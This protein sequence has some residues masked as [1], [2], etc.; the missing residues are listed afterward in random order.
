MSLSPL[1]LEAGNALLNNTGIRVAPILT[2]ALNKYN[3]LP[4]I[5]PLLTTISNASGVL[6]AN[7]I[8][9]LQT[10]G[11]N[12]CPA[13]S[14]S[15]P[16]GYTTLTVTT[17]PPGLTGL[18]S[19]T[20]NLY[21]GNGDVSKF[22]QT[23]SVASSYADSVNQFI[24][25]GVNSKTYLANTFSSMDNLTSA[26]LTFVTTDPKAFAKDI[27]KL[28]NL[29]NLANIDQLG[30]PLALVQQVI[31]LGGL[32]GPLI[33]YLGAGGLSSDQIITLINPN[34]DITDSDQKLIYQAMQE[35]T[36]ADLGQILQI[37]EVTTP[38]ITNM[39]DLLD[40]VKIFPNSYQTLI[41][42][43]CS[44]VENIYLPTPSTSST[45][46]NTYIVPYPGRNIKYGE[47]V[48]GYL[49]NAE[50]GSAYTT[51][52]GASGVVDSTGFAN[53]G[54][55]AEY[56][57]GYTTYTVH[58]TTGS[59]SETLFVT[60]P[61]NSWY[62]APTDPAWGSFMQTYA[63]W[64]G[65]VDAVTTN[66]IDTVI[67]CPTSGVYSI[68]YSCDNDL[69]WNFDNGAN[70]TSA[71]N[72]DTS[73]VITQTLS[74][75][76]HTLNISI[77]NTGGPGGVAMRITKPDTT[78]LW[79]T[80]AYAS[81]S[82]DSAVPLT[83]APAVIPT[84]GKVN[85]ILEKE[86]PV[87]AMDG[88]ETLKKI[89][90]ADQA[91]ADRALSISLQQIT[92][93]SNMSLPQLAK[94]YTTVETNT[95]LPDIVAQV[96]PV[97]NATI[98]YF[99]STSGLA[100]GTGQNGTI[101]LTDIIGTAIGAGVVDQIMSAVNTIVSLNSA[102]K[103]TTLTNIYNTMLNTING[104]YGTGPVVIPSG[105]AAG[106]YSNIESAFV[107]GLIPAARTEISAITVA[108]P[109]ETTNMTTAFVG[110]ATHLTGE[111]TYQTK[112]NLD[113]ANL[114]PNS[115]QA[116]QS[117]ITSIP[118]YGKNVFLGGPAEYL[119]AVANVEIIGGQAI[120]ASM[121]ESRTRTGLVLNGVGVYPQISTAPSTPL[122]TALLS[123]S[124]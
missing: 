70:V 98:N 73:T 2:A 124:T 116:I 119:E 22:A 16:K 109:N 3:T 67:N 36:D 12:T 64:T 21:I 115:Q 27:S 50:P 54:T 35:I 59:F 75:G 30:S 81:G 86:L 34:P 83:Q 7:T 52:W 5:S 76:Q 49:Y 23:L 20:A 89:I 103:L 118:E 123:S 112:A 111:Q 108:N 11:S 65:T 15:V 55:Y 74:A 25:A 80:L 18:I 100:T 66:V 14:D 48:Y 1:Q 102:G 53:L 117:F 92:N 94:S 60:S 93:I 39:A 37:L 28:G 51:S 96:Q 85:S 31:K 24:N 61:G 88:Y 57:P 4:E 17:T 101:L 69:S 77:T 95:G 122:P 97:A 26:D 68:E 45:G 10:L 63:I 91:L 47:V 84:T 71:S 43:T 9:N 113:I 19:N 79:N 99:T 41:T 44:A 42:P 8:A 72:F 33:V 78:E 46:Y 110:I 6:T 104:V 40:P 90:P 105:P 13:L 107:T 32:V 121:R 62:K 82:Y 114:T 87:Y 38:G 58:T 56:T 120:V 106:T 29:I